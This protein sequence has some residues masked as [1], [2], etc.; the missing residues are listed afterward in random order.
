MD[1][2]NNVIL[3]VEKLASISKLNLIWL[4][5]ISNMET[6]DSS[7]ECYLLALCLQFFNL[8]TAFVYLYSPRRWL[9]YCR[10]KRKIEPNFLTDSTCYSSKFF[11]KTIDPCYHKIFV[12]MPVVKS[13]ARFYRH[14]TN[15]CNTYLLC[16]I[17][18]S[19][20][21]CQ[22]QRRRGCSHDRH[23]PHWPFQWPNRCRS[24]LLFHR[25]HQP[26][27]AVNSVSKNWR[28]IFGWFACICTYAYTCSRLKH[29][30]SRSHW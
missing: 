7:N 9:V 23:R 14:D 12:T 1:T 28:F 24:L 17:A 21:L 5:R 10:R 13:L 26:V 18:Y 27:S 6:N 16:K 3:S 19:R 29:I 8:L 25:H 15:N 30:L 2:W 11:Q 22:Y 4:Y 20:V